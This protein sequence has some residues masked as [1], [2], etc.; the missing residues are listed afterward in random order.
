MVEHF[1]KAYTYL[2]KKYF[3]YGLE[4]KTAAYLIQYINPEIVHDILSM[5]TSAVYEN[6]TL[7]N[8]C[9]EFLIENAMKII[10]SK[11]F[12]NIS[13]E[14][15]KSFSSLNLQINDQQ[16]ALLFEKVSYILFQNHFYFD[17]RMV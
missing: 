8:A 12:K 2:A 6:I 15:L 16:K 1:F 14:Q 9:Q 13:P 7:I 4:D 10:S 5:S 11:I 17:I 3:I